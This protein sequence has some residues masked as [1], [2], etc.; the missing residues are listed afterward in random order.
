MKEKIY[1]IPGL[2][3]DFRLW[4]R[5]TPY[6]N[7]Y[8]LITLEIPKSDDFD[9]IIKLIDQKI[10]CDKINLLGFSLGG[11][12]ATYYSLKNPHRVNKLFLLSSTPSNT[13]QK[14]IPRR[15]EKLN[16]A[17]KSSFIPL[18]E[19]KALELLEI[20]DDKELL[21][22]TCAMFNDLGK[23]HFITQLSSTLKRVDLLDQLLKLQIPVRFYYSINDRLLNF[24]WLERLKKINHNFTLKHRE[25]TSHN[26][27]LE[28]PKELSLQIKEWM[29]E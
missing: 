2:M 23:E 1:L 25:G 13:E 17:R 21:E 20:K 29:Q 12:I 27:S 4:S 24:P 22:I 5:L 9:E 26:I 8:E 3:T 7:E 16:L 14:D 18:N 11:Y 10:T 19:K 28:F 15:Q 6:L